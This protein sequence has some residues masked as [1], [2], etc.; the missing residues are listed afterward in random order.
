MNRVENANKPICKDDYECP[1]LIILG[2]S[3]V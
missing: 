1:D 3:Q 2:T